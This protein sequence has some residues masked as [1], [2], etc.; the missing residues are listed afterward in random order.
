MAQGVGHHRFVQS[1][2]LA[3]NIADT[4]DGRERLPTSPRSAHRPQI[5]ADSGSTRT[6]VKVAGRGL[7]DQ[8]SA[9]L[10]FDP[11]PFPPLPHAHD[12]LSPTLDLDRECRVA[13]AA[14]SLDFSTNAPSEGIGTGPLL[15][16]WEHGSLRSNLRIF[17]RR[18]LIAFW[19]KHPDAE[20][21][22]RLWFSIVE[23]ASRTGPAD[24]RATFRTADFLRAN[25]VVFNI[26]GNAYRLVA[27]IMYSPLFLV[28]IRFIGTHAD[29]D[30]VG[31]TDV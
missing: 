5:E 7:A 30:R 8:P 14:S 28:F 20:Q 1:R 23:K 10:R 29:Y 12:S 2:E 9:S 16:R 26:K 3:R 11:T 24:V 19:T 18:T 22:L 27:Q 6:S 25:R 4:S 15:P 17:N 13:A 21:Q 31:A